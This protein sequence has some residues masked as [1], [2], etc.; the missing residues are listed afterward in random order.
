MIAAAKDGTMAFYWFGIRP[1]YLSSIPEKRSSD[2][3]TP[4]ETW[5]LHTAGC[6]EIEHSSAAPI[7]AGARWLMDSQSLI[8]REFGLSRSKKI[9]TDQ[10]THNGGVDGDIVR[11]EAPQDVFASQSQLPYC[12]VKARMGEKY[13]SVIADY[14][15]VVGMSDRVRTEP[16]VYDHN[17]LVILYRA[18]TFPG[19]LITSISITSYRNVLDLFEIVLCYGELISGV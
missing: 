3:P 10:N 5:S 12:D 6:F 8:V 4:W 17:I 15:W 19:R 7:P 14:E 11:R 1:D 9:I 2:R 13:R 18:T 16:P